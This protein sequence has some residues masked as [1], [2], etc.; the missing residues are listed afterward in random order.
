MQAL[1]LKWLTLVSVDETWS[2]FA[3]RPYRQGEARQSF[4]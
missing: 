1:D 2:A 3:L 4:R